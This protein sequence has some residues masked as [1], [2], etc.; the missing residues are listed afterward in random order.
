MPI[1]V[2]INKKTQESREVFQG[3]NETHEYFGENGDEK[4]WVREFTVPQASI[5]SKLPTSLDSFMN[6]TSNKRGTYGDM[7]ELSR[8]CS[9]KRKEKLGE[10]PIKRKKFDE[11]SKKRRGIKHEL[12]RPKVIKKDGATIEF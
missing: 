9:E 11:Y 7:M 4:D 6:T 3:M 8:E 10:D 2:Y 12:D 5:D 1:Y